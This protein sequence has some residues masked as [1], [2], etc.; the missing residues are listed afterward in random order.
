MA[1]AVPTLPT[2]VGV[3]V[4]IRRSVVETPLSTARARPVGVAA[5]V[6]MVMRRVAE[7]ADVLP[8]WSTAM[9][10]RVWVAALS[11]GR[12]SDQSPNPFAVTVASAVAPS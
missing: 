6:S 10:D 4:L 12:P 5:E 1:S 8:A 11:V 2:R 3:P 7:A 9:A